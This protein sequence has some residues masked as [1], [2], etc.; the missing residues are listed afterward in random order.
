MNTLFFFVEGSDDARFINKI[1]LP[2]MEKDFIQIIMIE[3]SQK[4]KKYIQKLI[5]SIMAT[6]GRYYFLADY[7][8]C[9]CFM[10]KKQI[11]SKLYRI[12]NNEKIFIVKREI[13]SWYAAGLDKNTCKKM[14]IPYNNTENLS[15]E[16]FTRCMI[17]SGYELRTDYMRD[18]LEMFNAE[19]AIIRNNSF[20]YFIRKNNINLEPC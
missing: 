19:I 16:K 18:I 4:T 13:E 2:K 14:K 8:E 5:K 3:Y 6:G 20:E 1:M 11:I 7:D 15:K 10:Q 17:S 12:D 9:K